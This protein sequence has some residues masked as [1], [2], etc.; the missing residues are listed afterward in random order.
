MPYCQVNMPTTSRTV[1][2]NS[3]APD[4]TLPAVTGGSITLS[5]YRHK[6][7][8]VLVFLRGFQ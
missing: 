8:V 3:H 7:R 4:F 2:I 6:S 1:P 5:D